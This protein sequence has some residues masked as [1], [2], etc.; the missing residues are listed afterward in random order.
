[1]EPTSTAT[2]QTPWMAGRRMR[3]PVTGWP[4]TQAPGVP[5]RRD[6]CRALGN[7]SFARDFVAPRVGPLMSRAPDNGRAPHGVRVALCP[8][9][10]KRGWRRWGSGHRMD[11]RRRA[12]CHG[13][14]HVK[15]ASVPDLQLCGSLSS[16]VA[17]PCSHPALPLFLSQRDRDHAGRRRHPAARTGPPRWGLWQE[18]RAPRVHGRAVGRRGQS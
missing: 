18:A 5:T 16:S 17:G 3:S 2:R 12:D 11:R 14:A 6:T 8:S 7:V 15:F 13:S 9:H 1:M 4:V 10:G